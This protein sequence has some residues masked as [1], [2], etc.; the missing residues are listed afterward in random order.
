MHLG[1][2]AIEFKERRLSHAHILVWLSGDNKQCIYR[3]IDKI[4]LTKF[5]I[6]GCIQTKLFK[7]F[8]TFK[9]CKH[10]GEINQISHCKKDGKFS[11]YYPTDIN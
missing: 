1:M 9:I 7:T 2:Y 5:L 10:C 3:D 11:K 4:I 6:E 8:M